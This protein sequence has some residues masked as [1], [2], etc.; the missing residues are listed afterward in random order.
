MAERLAARSSTREMLVAEL[1]QALGEAHVE[2]RILRR[3]GAAG[4][5]SGSWR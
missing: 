3:G 5:P 4:F 1:T 2:L